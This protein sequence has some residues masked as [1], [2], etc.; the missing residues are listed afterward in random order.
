MLKLFLLLQEA[1]T[2]SIQTLDWLLVT[3]RI[4][5]QITT[6]TRRALRTQQPTYLA[7]LIHDPAPI[8]SLH[9]SD[10][11]LLQQP[12]TNTMTISRAF[13]VAAPRIWNSLPAGINALLTSKTKLKTHLFATQRTK[14]WLCLIFLRITEQRRLLLEPYLYCIV[15]SQLCIC[16]ARSKWRSGRWRLQHADDDDDWVAGDCHGTVLATS[17]ITQTSV[18]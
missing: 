4:T 11:R 13:T 6:I 12:R 15:F 17:G 5:Y 2:D 18:K 14:E 7:K 10:R 9:S 3:E 8:R 1:F 16:S